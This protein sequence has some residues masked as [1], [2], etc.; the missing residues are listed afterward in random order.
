MSNSPSITIQT[1]PVEGTK[2]ALSAQLTFSSIEQLRA[3]AIG[4]AAAIAGS[5]EYPTV[6][7]KLI[8]QALI[9]IE[10]RVVEVG[11]CDR[12]CV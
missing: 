12:E 5:K 2:V 11:R 8:T 3:D 4:K 1:A 10:E 6:L 9:K 7:Q